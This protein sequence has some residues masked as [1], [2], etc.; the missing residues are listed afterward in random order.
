MAG[1]SE[2]YLM[3]IKSDLCELALA[4]RL[5][6]SIPDLNLSCQTIVYRALHYRT[7]PTSLY[8]AWR[9]AT[10][11]RAFRDIHNRQ[12]CKTVRAIIFCLNLTNTP[13]SLK[14]ANRFKVSIDHQFTSSSWLPCE[15]L[16]VE[17]SL[18]LAI[19]PGSFL[20][21][22]MMKV[23]VLDTGFEDFLSTFRSMP[24]AWRLRSPPY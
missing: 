17:G 23:H 10:R 15:K 6:F 5:I 4:C 16:F 22:R 7:E 11:Q 14:C 19:S 9:S 13:V 21:M 18:N 2:D 1:V 12:S 8:V 3:Y 24:K 20:H